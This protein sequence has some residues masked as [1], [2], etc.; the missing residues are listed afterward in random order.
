MFGKTPRRLT[1]AVGRLDP[2]EPQKAAGPR[3]EPPVSVPTAPGTNPA[4]TAAPAPLDEPPGRRV[5]VP[6]VQRRRPW[7]VPAR[8]AEG[9]FP[10]R[11][12]AQQNAAAGL[13]PDDDLGVGRR[14]MILAQLRMP[15]GA[16]AGGLDDV[17]QRVGDAVQR[18]AAR[19]GHQF[20]FGRAGFGER[21][22]LGDEQE[23]VQFAVMRGD[24]S[25]SVC[26][27]STGDSSRL[28]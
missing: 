1:R 7:Q 12:L 28:S 10:G 2:G 20:A 27:T 22:L 14:H 6:G 26:V 9:E 18:P 24:R 13:E 4:A 19:P 23:A 3:T 25:S 11:Q 21:D 15:G 16:D 5:C 17:L 8:A